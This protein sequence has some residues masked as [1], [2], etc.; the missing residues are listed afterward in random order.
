[1]SLDISDK[2]QLENTIEVHS[3]QVII[4]TAAITNV[5]I[6]HTDR[7][8]RKINVD[9]VQH[10]VDVCERQNIH[11]IHLSTDFVFDGLNGPYSEEDEPNPVSIYGE[12]KLAAEQIILNSN[13]KWSILRT[14]LVYGVTSNMSRSNIVLWAKSALERGEPINVVTDQWRMPTLV[15]DLAEAC[16]LTAEKGATDIFHVSGSDMMTIYDLVVQV[17]DFW[18]LNKSLI[19]P[20]SSASLNQEA[21]R[22]LKT[23]FRLEKAE[24][25]LGFKPRSFS[26]GLQVVK[27]RLETSKSKAEI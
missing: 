4:N 9:S 3:P 11:L 18:S 24:K 13:C 7:E 20:I 6:C 12:S 17:A 27:S 5:D 19:R 15:D 16:L 14:I 8:C 26:Q 2:T 21:K 25:V 1:V 23:G 22:P 10:L